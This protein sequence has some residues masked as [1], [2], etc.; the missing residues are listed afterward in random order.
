L[1]NIIDGTDRARY[2]NKHMRDISTKLSLPFSRSPDLLLKKFRSG[3]NLARIVI[4]NLDN[5]TVISESY[6]VAFLWVQMIM[7]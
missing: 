3:E 1:L 5:P 6:L 4:I 2:G 7:E